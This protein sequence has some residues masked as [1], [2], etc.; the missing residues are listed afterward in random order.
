MNLLYYF[1]LLFTHQSFKSYTIALS[2]SPLPNIKNQFRHPRISSFS[3]GPMADVP[4]II[5]SWNC[6]ELNGQEITKLS[7][8]VWH[9]VH[10]EN[11]FDL[12]SFYG[13]LHFKDKM[14]IGKVK[15]LSPSDE[16]LKTLKA[17]RHQ[18]IVFYIIESEPKITDEVRVAHCHTPQLENG[19]SVNS[20]SL[21]PHSEDVQSLHQLFG[22]YFVT[23]YSKIPLQ[24]SLERRIILN[25]HSKLEASLFGEDENREDCSSEDFQAHWTPKAEA[26]IAVLH[27][28]DAVPSQIPELAEYEIRE[29]SLQETFYAVEHWKFGSESAKCR[30]ACSCDLGLTVGAFQRGGNAPVSWAFASWDGSISALQTLPGHQGKGLAKAVVRKLSAKLISIGI[31]PFVH[32]EMIETSFVPESLFTSLGFQLYK[33]FVFRWK[34]PC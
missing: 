26:F 12:L 24:E 31:H 2:Q 27:N 21:P 22:K 4:S 18:P 10:N 20:L 23:T 3:K 19:V 33:D 7:E 28:P 8:D 17:N 34:Y 25:L 16:L 32:I 6:V 11:R 15:R 1:M 13:F 14:W 5:D 30:F 29:M 9:M